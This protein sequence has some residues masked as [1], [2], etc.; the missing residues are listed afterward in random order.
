MIIIPRRVVCD[1]APAGMHGWGVVSGASPDIEAR[2]GCLQAELYRSDDAGVLLDAL[3]KMPAGH[4]TSVL[5]AVLESCS[6]KAMTARLESRA[7]TL[8]AVVLSVKAAI[9]DA[10]GGVPLLSWP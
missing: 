3:A 9:P 7:G 1:S 10:D 2:P 8:E 5:C 6:A 4:H